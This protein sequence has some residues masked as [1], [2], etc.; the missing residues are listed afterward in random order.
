MLHLEYSPTRQGT[1]ALAQL[2]KLHE[3]PIILSIAKT[4]IDLCPMLTMTEKCSIVK[5]ALLVYFMY[6]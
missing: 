4:A 3:V 2:S 5:M 1:E 6:D